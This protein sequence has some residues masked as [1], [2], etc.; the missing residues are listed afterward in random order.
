[1]KVEAEKLSSY[2]S[3]A[4]NGIG[5]KGT[6]ALNTAITLLNDEGKLSL[7]TTTGIATL[8]VSTD[9][10]AQDFTSCS[11][12]NTLFVNL[13]AKLSGEIEIT[14]EEGRY[15]YI[16]GKGE[17]KIPLIFDYNGNLATI[18]EVERISEGLIDLDIEELDRAIGICKNA[19]P[20]DLNVPILYNIA[21]GE[22]V[23]AT[24]DEKMIS[25]PNVTKFKGL[26]S[27]HNLSIITSVFKG[28]TQYRINGKELIIQDDTSVVVTVIDNSDAFPMQ[29]VDALQFDNSFEVEYQNMM[30]VLDKGKLFISPFDRNV[31]NLDIMQNSIILRSNN[32][33]FVEEVVYASPNTVEPIEG[34]KVNLLD[35]YSILTSCTNGPLTLSCTEDGPLVVKQNDYEGLVSLYE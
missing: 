5:R 20:E 1:M 29:V 16:R 33:D 30:D 27:V 6:S 17:Y 7:L 8:K 2:V 4:V 11:L 21:F 35:L 26:L 14:I 19:C 25:I 32:N 15:L 9:I 34:L 31:I 10:D 22:K 23:V 12:E 24:N 18:P 28:N 13:L 3:I